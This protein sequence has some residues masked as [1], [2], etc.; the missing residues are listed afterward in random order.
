MYMPAARTS[1]TATTVT[2]SRRSTAAP[3][4]TL[5]RKP[6]EVNIN[7]PARHLTA[8]PLHEPA[9]EAG[10]FQNKNTEQNSPYIPSAYEE[11]RDTHVHVYFHVRHQ[12]PYIQQQN[13]SA[14]GISG[15]KGIMCVRAQ[16]DLSPPSLCRRHLHAPRASPTSSESEVHTQTTASVC[17]YVYTDI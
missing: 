3:I 13:Q 8:C 15:E 1:P 5:Y 11:T 2:D 12:H 10:P 4:I 9:A 7:T 16:P 6:R 17:V 14:A